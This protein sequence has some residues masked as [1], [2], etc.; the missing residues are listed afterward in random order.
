M[1]VSLAL[2][3][4]GIRILQNKKSPEKTLKAH[5]FCGYRNLNALR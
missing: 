3:N 4:K 2:N 1:R 5:L